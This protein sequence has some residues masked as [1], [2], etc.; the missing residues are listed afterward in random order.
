MVAHQLLEIALNYTLCKVS[1]FEVQLKLGLSKI[2]MAYDILLCGVAAVMQAF[3]Q[4]NAVW[5]RREM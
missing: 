3:R 1:N 4:V 2:A 5:P